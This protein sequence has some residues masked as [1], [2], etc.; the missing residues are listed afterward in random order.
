[1]DFPEWETYLK[2]ESKDQNDSIDE[3]YIV[4]EIPIPIEA[5][6]DSTFLIY[7]MDDEITVCFD[8]YHSHFD[9]WRNKNGFDQNSA[10]SF[11][12]NLLKE[13]VSVVSYWENIQWKGSRQITDMNDYKPNHKIE[14]NKV[15]IRSWNGKYNADIEIA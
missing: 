15:R 1:M 2:I 12:V 4:F 6:V 13:K 8:Y 7:T 11:I 14:Y 9:D 5:N 3:T 10:Y